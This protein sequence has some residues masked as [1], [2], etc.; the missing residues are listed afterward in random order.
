MSGFLHDLLSMEVKI[1]M[2]SIQEIHTYR[3]DVWLIL[4]DF[5]FRLFK[6]GRRFGSRDHRGW[7]YSLF[8]HILVELLCRKLPFKHSHFNPAHI[9]K[10]NFF[11]RINSRELTESKMTIWVY[12]ARW[13]MTI[14]VFISISVIQK[15]FL[16][17]R[18]K[19]IYQTIFLIKFYILILLKVIIKEFICDKKNLTAG[20]FH[21]SEASEKICETS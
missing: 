13:K 1:W 12:S 2:N 6:S 16:F 11:I 14:F 7:H 5:L 21:E 15:K 10:T 18:L 17:V 3:L 8:L 4:A 9:L 20:S 19:R